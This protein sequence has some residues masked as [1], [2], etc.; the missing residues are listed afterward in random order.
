[1]SNLIRLSNNRKAPKHFFFDQQEMRL[2]L[3]LYTSRVMSG[4]WRD[5]ALD[6]R[7]GMA[8]F[9]I[10]RHSHETA[11]YSIQKIQKKGQKT[12]SFQLFHGPKKLKSSQNLRD[13]MGVF[14]K[15]PRLVQG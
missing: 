4:E 6:R 15:L 7:D 12:P 8:V 2:L 5:Y 14:E 13:L 1:M 11:L 3:N 9:S 10:F